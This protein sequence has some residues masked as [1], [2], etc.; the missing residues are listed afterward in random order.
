[1]QAIRSTNT[2]PELLVRSAVF[3]AGYRFRL[4]CRTLPGTPDLVFSAR[5]KV[6]FVH[7]C[8]WHSHEGCSKAYRPKSREAFWSEKLQKNKARDRRV[9][10]AIRALGWEPLVVWE[11][12]AA[13]GEVLRERLG[14]FLGPPRI[15]PANR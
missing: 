5:R 4:H 7:G 6:I 11:C 3:G 13:D 2:K 9:Q 12:E 8:F 1:M 15:R 14:D 10:A